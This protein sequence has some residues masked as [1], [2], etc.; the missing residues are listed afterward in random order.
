VNVFQG[1]FPCDPASSPT[2]LAAGEVRPVRRQ[3]LLHVLH[4]RLHEAPV[5]V[6]ANIRNTWAEK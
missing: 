3:G 2:G 5:V 1:G 4:C 6:E